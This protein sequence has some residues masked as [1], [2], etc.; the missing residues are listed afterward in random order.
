MRPGSSVPPCPSTARSDAPGGRSDSGPI[1]VIRRPS[2]MTAR[3][4]ASGAPVPSMMPTF[5][6]TEWL[7]V[8]DIVSA[9]R[10]VDLLVGVR[11][12]GEVN[13]LVTV[14]AIEHEGLLSLGDLLQPERT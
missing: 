2:V 7:V 4:R 10:S 3:S 13:D 9:S 5:L 8:S 6:M 14:V 12:V 1:Q 11:G